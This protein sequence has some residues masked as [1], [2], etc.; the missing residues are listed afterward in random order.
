MVRDRLAELQ[1]NCDAV[2][3]LPLNHRYNVQPTEVEYRTV[4]QQIDEVLSEYSDI[5]DGINEIKSNVQSMRNLLLE[6]TVEWSAFLEHFYVIILIHILYFAALPEQMDAL[7]Q[8]NMKLCQQLFNKMRDLEKD[9][10]NGDDQEIIS[11]IKRTNFYCVRDDFLTA[12]R[13]HESFLVVY[14]GKVKKTLM[15]QAK[16]IDQNMTEEETESLINSKT[17]SLF[18]GNIIEE[19]EHARSHLRDL[20]V[21]HSELTKIEKSLTEVRDMFLRISTLVMEQNALIQVVEYHAQ[22][23]SI[24]V[25]KGT[26]EL[27]QAKDLKIKAT[28]KKFWIIFWIILVLV[29][30]ILIMWLL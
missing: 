12:W 4:D 17:T 5:R 9:L 1:K 10:P 19:T 30:L 23:A 25:D 28:K 24:N 15:R 21:R 13:E 11:R 22:T 18:V 7:R 27:E 16:I 26:G 3:Y 6:L 20:L 8:G 2:S 14:E 29:I